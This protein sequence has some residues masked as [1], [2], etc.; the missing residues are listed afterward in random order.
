METVISEGA[1]LK[2]IQDNVQVLFSL[3]EKISFVFN[4]LKTSDN[5]NSQRGLFDSLAKKT[6]M[7]LR[8]MIKDNILSRSNEKLVN[9]KEIETFV[10]DIVV[11]NVIDLEI[12]SDF[13][14]NIQKQ[15]ISSLSFYCLRNALMHLVNNSFAH[16][17]I[18][19]ESYLIT[20]SC[21][22]DDGV[23]S[24]TYKDN[25]GGIDTDKIRKIISEKDSNQKLTEKSDDEVAQLIFTPDLSTKDEVDELSGEELGYLLLFWM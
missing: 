2:E 22:F 9:L 20:T 4:A 17:F 21:D 7:K 11:K 12:D 23:L 10:Q 19:G 16:G 15:Y 3:W 24:F 25:G 8:S 13:E 14:C 18:Q 1:I 5:K 6:N